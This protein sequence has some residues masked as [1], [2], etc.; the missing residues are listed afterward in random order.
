MPAAPAPR[1]IS[2]SSHNEGL[3]VDELI[4]KTDNGPSYIAGTGVPMPDAQPATVRPLEPAPQVTASA[5]LGPAS[6]EASSGKAIS[7]LLFVA[8]VCLGGYAAWLYVLHPPGKSVASPQASR[9]SGPGSGRRAK[10][11][12]VG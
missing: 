6:A 5:S 2:L 3:V 7:I 9:S 11:P 8:L 4:A 10:A 1:A 12:E